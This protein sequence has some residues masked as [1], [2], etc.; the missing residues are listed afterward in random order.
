MSPS[1]M[2][3]Q[4]RA[5]QEKQR[6]LEQDVSRLQQVIVP[7]NYTDWWNRLDTNWKILFWQNIR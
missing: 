3:A 5:L 4:L 6:S 2:E 1:E 7:T